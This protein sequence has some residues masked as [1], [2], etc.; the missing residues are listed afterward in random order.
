MAI[1]W[2]YLGV[3]SKFQELLWGLWSHLTSRPGMNILAGYGS[4]GE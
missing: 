3:M 2:W 1:E 4:Y